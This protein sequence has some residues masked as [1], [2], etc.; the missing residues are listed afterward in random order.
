MSETEARQ[1]VRMAERALHRASAPI[2]YLHR[3]GQDGPFAAIITAG[4]DGWLAKI[5]DLVPDEKDDELTD[6]MMNHGHVEGD[7]DDELDGS[8]WDR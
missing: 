2:C 8:G 1:I 5:E 3:T 6:I 7:E 4:A